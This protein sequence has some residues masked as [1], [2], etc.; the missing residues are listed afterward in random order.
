MKIVFFFNSGID[1]A[2]SIGFPEAIIKDAKEIAAEIENNF[3][4]KKYS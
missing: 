4:V 1:L 2:E 3:E